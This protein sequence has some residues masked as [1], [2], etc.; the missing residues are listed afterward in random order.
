MEAFAHELHGALV[1]EAKCSN[2]LAHDTIR[3]GPQGSTFAMGVL[4]TWMVLR[5][6]IRRSTLSERPTE[7]S[8]EW[9]QN[10]DRQ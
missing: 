5:G 10:I 7:D 9:F 2:H 6:D 4:S 3:Q 1:L 8:D